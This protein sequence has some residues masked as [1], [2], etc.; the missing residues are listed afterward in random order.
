[1]KSLAVMAFSTCSINR[2]QYLESCI[3]VVPGSDGLLNVLHYYKV[4]VV[5]AQVHGG[6][7]HL[8]DKNSKILNCINFQNLICFQLF[9]QY[10]YYTVSDPDPTCF[11]RH[12]DRISFS[13]EGPDLDEDPTSSC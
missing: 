3:D 9:L 10:R 1:M 13:W 2:V 4:C 5:V 12:M 6:Y 11:L 7:S 8:N